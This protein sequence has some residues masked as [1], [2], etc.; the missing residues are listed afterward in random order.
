MEPFILKNAEFA[1]TLYSEI[2]I[3]EKGRLTHDLAG[4]EIDLGG[5]TVMPGFIDI[6]DHGAAGIDVNVCNS[7]TLRDVGMFLVQH[8][9]TAWMPTL[10][11]DSDET[12]ARV[13]AAIDDVMAEQDGGD[14]ARI[15][16]LHY[17]G[18]FANAK[19]C[20]AL[21]PQYF[22]KFSG[23]GLDELPRLRS[24]AHMMTF[25]PEIDGGAELAAELT[26]RGWIASIGHT[27]ASAEL[28]DAAK[29]AG[30]RHITHFFNAM[31]GIHHRELGVAGW[32][33]ANKDVT[34]DIIADG[35]HVCEPMLELACRIKT[36]ANVSLIS[37]SIAPT[38][39]GDGDFEMWGE[40][41]K[42]R[43]GSTENERGSIAGSVITMLDAVKRMRR[44][45]FSNGDVA[46][47][48]SGNPAR[49]LGIEKE[50]GSIEADKRADLV[51]L[52]PA[53]DL[54]AT[55][56]GGRKVFEAI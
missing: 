40:K 44:L 54:I 51:V 5:A 22:K 45:G 47:M 23:S 17:E 1:G 34:F 56:I 31:S 36:P 2:G 50:C 43:E 32:A 38:G 30:A 14:A 28:L 15:V 4:K 37:D 21:R 53:G 7:D 27:N 39:L 49:L 29:A 13:A 18:V 9:V 46:M 8:G 24:G 26:R 33:L 3:N 20:G 10:V 11:P 42:V 35:R 6:H 16:G 19:M 41:I 12:Y 48:A 55:Y 25:A 52:T